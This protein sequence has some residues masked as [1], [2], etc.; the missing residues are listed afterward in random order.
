MHDCFNYYILNPLSTLFPIYTYVL[1]LCVS[2][3]P[4]LLHFINNKSLFAN[5]FF[6]LNHFGRQNLSPNHLRA[7]SHAFSY[8]LP[9]FLFFWFGQYLYS[10]PIAASNTYKFKILS[11]LFFFSFFLQVQSKYVLQLVVHS[12]A[13][14]F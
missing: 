13:T 10:I 2:Q 4:N 12:L 1:S 11:L 9:S 3:S 14:N 7:G 8:I 6:T 5:T